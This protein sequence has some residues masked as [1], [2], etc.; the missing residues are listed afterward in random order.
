MAAEAIIK[1]NYSALERTLQVESILGMLFQGD[2]INNDQMKYIRNEKNPLEQ[3][4]ILLD[5]LMKASIDQMVSFADILEKSAIEQAHI[6]HK[7]LS[8]R[9]KDTIAEVRRTPSQDASSS[10]QGSGRP[11]HNRSEYGSRSS[12]SS[13]HSQSFFPKNSPFGPNFPFGPEGFKFSASHGKGGVSMQQNTVIA[14]NK[15][16][17]STITIMG[18]AQD[19]RVLGDTSQQSK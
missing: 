12:S 14:G 19:T 10:P 2:L 6:H 7:E 17:N 9:L 1:K 16:S 4:R 8:A 3:R 15:I 18:A 11:A 13:S 5:Y